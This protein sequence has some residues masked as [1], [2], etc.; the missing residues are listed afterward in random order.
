MDEGSLISR[1]V[2]GIPIVQGIL[3]RAPAGCV[4]GEGGLLRALAEAEDWLQ[5]LAAVGK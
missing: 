3:E 5:E 2:A 1:A 4:Q